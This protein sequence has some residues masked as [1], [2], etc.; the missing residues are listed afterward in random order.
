MSVRRGTLAP[1]GIA[2]RI[3]LNPTAPGEV[4]TL[5]MFLPNADE[6]TTYRYRIGDA[7]EIPARAFWNVATADVT[8]TTGTTTVTVRA[9]NG[10]VFLGIATADF[11]L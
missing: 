6:V 3:V 9:F 1:A 11:A 5:L 7:D 10:D 8:L 2:P 4:S